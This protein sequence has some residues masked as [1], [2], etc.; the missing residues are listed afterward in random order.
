MKNKDKSTFRRIIDAFGGWIVR[1]RI[2]IIVVIALLTGLTAYG[3]TQTNINS[4][5]MSYL[6]E[7]TDTYDGSAFLKQNFG[8]QSS[9]AYA[10]KGDSVTYDDLALVVEKIKEEEHVSDVMWLGSMDSI[11]F[12]G[13]PVQNPF[14]MMEGGET[15]KEKLKNIFYRDGNYMLMIT[16][17][18][19]ASTDEAGDALKVINASLN[20]IH[21]EYTSGGTAPVSRT[22]YDNAISELPIYLVVAVVLVLIILFLVSA[23]WLEPIVFMLTMGVSIVINMG[24]NFFFPEVSIITFCA[25]SIL[26]LALAM[27]YS[28]FLTQIYS[29]ERQKGLPIRGAMIGAIGTTLNT[30]FASA[31][32][33][34]GG[35]AAFFVMSF[36]LGAD[37]GGVLIKGIFLAMLTVIILQPCLLILLSKPMAKTGH[38]R[39]VDIK[40]RSVAKFSVRHRIIIVILFSLILIPAFI[41]QLLMPLSYLNF[42]P[43][44]KGNPELVAYVSDT[45]NQIFLAVPVDEDHIEKNLTFADEL[46]SIDGVSGVSGYFAFLPKEAVDEKG[47]IHINKYM[48]LGLYELG[49]ETGYITDDGYTLYLVS[50]SK[51][52]DV[53]S[54]EA[55]NILFK[56]KD[57]ASLTFSDSKTYTTGVVQAV[58]DF[59]VLTPRDF[60]WITIISIAI[61]FIVL[62]IS[63]RNFVYPFLLVLLIELGTWINFSICTIFGQSLNFLA[64]IVV[65]AIQL[66]ATVDYAILVT[67]K[68]RA[69]TKEGKDPLLAAYESGTSCTMSIL[70][71]ASIL[72]AA[73]AS[74]TII[75]TN[76]V[77]CEVT[78]MCMR[79]AVISTILVL[80]VLPSLLA[81][82][83]RIS[84]RAAEAGG[85]HK[86]T[87]KFLSDVNHQLHYAAVELKTKHRVKKEGLQNKDETLE[88][89]ETRGLVILQPKKGYRFNSD[90]VI[91]A[92]LTE[93]SEGEKVYDL[94]CGSGVI[95]L[96]I[97]AKKHAK[98]VGVELQ[99][100]LASMAERSVKANEYQEKI[101]I[102]RGDI[103]LAESTLSSED[104]D[105]VVINPP[106]FKMGD[107]V[108]NHD[109][110]SAI[111]RHEVALT[112]PEELAAVHH[113][114]KESGTAYFLFPTSREKEFDKEVETHSLFL[115]EKI[116]LTASAEKASDRFIAKLTKISPESELTIRTLVTQN[117]EGKMSKEVAV[118]YRS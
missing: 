27:D 112:L 114:L 85:M 20:E 79:G 68:Y 70:T 10:I 51:E 72:I 93:V 30:V 105:V 110:M 60:R 7:G 107:G 43:E 9:A 69:L 118:L 25:A 23:N 108:V 41:G 65:G 36:T 99:E 34:M 96:I 19:G 40:F 57:K 78:M 109:E 89:L 52:Y 63:F 58:A 54:M 64:Y 81:C 90:S 95:S 48:S 16:M 18:V 29:E 3:I 56:I 13:T 76:A 24:T 55:T 1:F 88:S 14:S 32:T 17:D 59:R 37:L 91:L 113:L 98:V 67:H 101:E 38:K 115:R 28:I 2:P 8:I 100:S 12:N 94:G 21:A 75:S 61:I 84:S 73:C 22:V 33:T 42:M 47:N 53:E 39:I 116:Y 4:D 87:K 26:Q 31:L 97:A 11:D 74:V 44:T 46:A 66:G 102:V 117:G 15:S 6:P 71:S 80:F 111:A 50:L 35:F 103:R 82:T 106:Y 49:Q 77:I 5:I 104:A 62:L 92:N 86:L 45:S 83:S